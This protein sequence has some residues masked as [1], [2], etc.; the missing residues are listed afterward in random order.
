MILG[1]VLFFIGALVLLCIV[2]IFTNTIPKARQR[3]RQIPRKLPGY[4]LIPAP[5]GEI[6]QEKRYTFYNKV[7]E[8]LKRKKKLAQQ[9]KP[10][11]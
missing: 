8:D 1:I 2:M 7:E 4:E 9:L 5:D 11:E 10:R 3:S 6:K